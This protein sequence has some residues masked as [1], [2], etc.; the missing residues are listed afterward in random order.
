M[1]NFHKIVLASLGIMVAVAVVLIE[2]SSSQPAEHAAMPCNAPLT[3]RIGD[4]DP[5]F[6]IDKRTIKKLM[7][8]AA[9]AWSKAAGKEIVRFSDSG[10][11]AIH[12]IYSEDQQYT[13]N[14]QQLSQRIRRQETEY[15]ALQ[16][17]YQKLSARY[18]QE[19]EQYKASSQE[20][21]EQV[22]KYNADIAKLSMVS[23]SQ[24]KSLDKKQK[25][26]LQIQRELDRDRKQLN[27]LKDDVN[28]VADK[29]NN[30]ADQ[31]NAL[32]YHYNE[33]YSNRKE[34]DQGTYIQVG[35]TRKI[36]IYQYDNPDNLRLALAHEIGHALGLNHVDNPKS[37]MYYLMEK[38]DETKLQFTPE[39]IE[40]LEWVCG[41]YL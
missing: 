5:R 26:I 32:V 23:Q 4:V 31:I 3:Y 24:K 6:G 25:K 8:D 15:D 17:E 19:V 40:E 9:T 12:F 35:D 27:N 10:K 1:L 37:V 33:R 13:R 29:L 7:S 20:F 34:F 22:N 18:Q 28:H 39:D 41:D 21:K 2:S 38:Q 14:E 11:V 30:M 36:N 16:S